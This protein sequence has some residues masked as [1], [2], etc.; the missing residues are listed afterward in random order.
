MQWFTF[1]QVFEV[2]RDI[3]LFKFHFNKPRNMAYCYYAIYIVYP[4]DR[5]SKGSIVFLILT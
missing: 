2:V 4:C 1:E 3:D 5:T